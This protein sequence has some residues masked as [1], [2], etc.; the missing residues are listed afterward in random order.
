MYQHH[1]LKWLKTNKIGNSMKTLT[2]DIQSSLTP[3]DAL[4]ILKGGN[5]EET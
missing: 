5:G 4:T 2:K 3:K 1:T